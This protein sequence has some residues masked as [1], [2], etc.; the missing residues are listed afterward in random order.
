MSAYG[1]YL[2][3]V[4]LE[5]ICKYRLI[6]FQILIQDTVV[7]VYTACDAQAKLALTVAQIYMSV[8]HLSICVSVRDSLSRVC[9]Q[10][11]CAS[12]ATSTTGLS[13]YKMRDTY[14]VS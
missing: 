13:R 7:E 1:M 9:T 14:F 5:K 8:H 6:V 4:F 11:H 12:R 2:S 10:Q 3:I